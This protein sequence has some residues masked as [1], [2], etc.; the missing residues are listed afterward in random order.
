ML[1]SWLFLEYSRCFLRCLYIQALLVCLVMSLVYSSCGLWHIEWISSFW[2]YFL[3]LLCAYDRAPLILANL[4]FRKILTWYQ[5]SWGES[6]H[7]LFETTILL[8]APQ[9]ESGVSLSLRVSRARFDLSITSEKLIR[10]RLTINLAIS[11]QSWSRGNFFLQTNTQRH[12]FANL[13][14]VIFESI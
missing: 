13:G 8:Q 11:G 1:T 4:A 3:D 10:W 6:H 9:L 12:R 14:M 2:S 5:S 7:F